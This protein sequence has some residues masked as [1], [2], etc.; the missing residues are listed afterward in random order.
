MPETPTGQYEDCL[1]SFGVSFRRMREGLG[2]SQRDVAN[3]YRMSQHMISAAE[4]GRAGLSFWTMCRLADA[5]KGE[6][7]TMLWAGD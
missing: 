3:Q 5:V 4:N 2:L 1:R 6:I 7:R